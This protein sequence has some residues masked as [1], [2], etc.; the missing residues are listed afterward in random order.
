MAALSTAGIV[1]KGGDTEVRDFLEDNNLV[2]FDGDY[3]GD[4]NEVIILGGAED[5]RY[6]HPGSV[7]AWLIAAS[8]TTIRTSRAGDLQS[9]HELHTH[10]P[11]FEI[12]TVDDIDLTPWQ[13]SLI[14]AIEGGRN[15]G[16][17]TAPGSLCAAGGSLRGDFR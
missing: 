16:I 14:R 1:V 9:C 8:R 13:I 10:L 6:Y 5:E 12:S 3:G 4:L 7:D 15:Y 17:R 2:R 11:E